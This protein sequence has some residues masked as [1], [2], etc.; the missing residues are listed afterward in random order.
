VDHNVALGTSG[1]LHIV[2]CKVSDKVK[3]KYK[4]FTL[5]RDSFGKHPSCKK[6]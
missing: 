1:L 3:G 2:K 4:L 6:T 5:N